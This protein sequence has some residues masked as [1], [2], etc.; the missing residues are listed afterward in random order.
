[1]STY[2]LQVTEVAQAPGL[3]TG[4]QTHSRLHV[5][6]VPH[7]QDEAAAI[8]CPGVSTTEEAWGHRQCFPPGHGHCVPPWQRVHSVRGEQ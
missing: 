3:L 7:V 2:G 4:G 5:R 1:M 6:L 8:T